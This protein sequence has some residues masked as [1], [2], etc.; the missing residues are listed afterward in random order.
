M[1]DTVDLREFV[2]GFI[3]ESDQLVASAI[4]G[5]LA[6]EQANARGELLPKTVRDLFR[7]LHTLKGLAG[8]M[9]IQPIV[10]LAHGFETVVRAADQA[11][12]RL[13]PRA[14]ELGLMAVRAIA[15]RVRAVADERPIAPAPEPV[16]DELARVDATTGTATPAT[17]ITA[18]WDRK[19]SAGERSQLAAA[20]QQGRKAYTLTFAP[21]EETSARG[22][23]IATVRSAL[24]TLGDIIKVLPRTVPAS[25]QAPAGLLFELLVLSDADVAELARAAATTPEQVEPVT[26]QAAPVEQV[27]TLATLPAD[28]EAAPI[29]RSFVR[30]ELS[31]LDDLQEQLSAL[32]VSRFRLERQIGKLGEAGHDVRALREIADTQARQLRDLRRGILRA[33]MVRV[34]EVL[35]PLTLLVRSLVK[36]GVK[37][38]KLEVDVRD[39]ELDKAV[40][41]R[42]LPAIVHLVRNAIDHAIEPIVERERAGK[43]RAGRVRIACYEGAGNVLEL[44][45]SDDGRGIDRESIARRVGRPI[46]DEAALLDVLTAPGFSTREA[47]T[48]TSGRGLGMDIVRRVVVR[49][50]GGELTLATEVGAGSTFT[51][52]VPLTI[53]IIDVFSFEC[54]SQPFVVP[55]ATV[56]EIIEIADTKRIES[57]APDG[58]RLPIQLLE[59]RGRPLPVIALGTILRL[60]AHASTPSKALVVRRK[61]EPLAFGIDRMLG[62]HEVVV[63]PIEDVLAR[64][65]GVAGA[66]DLGDGRPTLLLDLCEL[67]AS[68]TS[69]RAEASS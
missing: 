24:A 60:A 34:A 12:G 38:V 15:E 30:V 61:G 10:E 39:T 8:M 69:W 58:G 65:P 14:V 35:E 22:V 59:R 46:N 19:L 31:R 54:G 29:G 5:L 32:V 67:G 52:R 45:I 28:E 21:S 55:V 48:H 2:G 62:R 6:I 36:P 40:A 7:A 47:V 4:A 1:A 23:S 27:P 57:P 56:D 42:L 53:A 49:D 11:G 43:P 3:A 20:L 44:S 17:T 63:R 26:V 50:L 13:S 25:P 51:L 64:V 66:T 9:A 18:A 37:E 41:D 33:R 68:A 16:I